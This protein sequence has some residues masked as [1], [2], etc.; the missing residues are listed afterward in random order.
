MILEW[1]FDGT[2]TTSTTLTD[3]ASPPWRPNTWSVMPGRHSL[4]KAAHEKYYVAGQT[5]EG[6]YIQVA[7]VLDPDDTAYIIHARPLTGPEKRKYRRRIR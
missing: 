3:T 2:R 4:Q 7:Y 5:R 1:N 6:Q